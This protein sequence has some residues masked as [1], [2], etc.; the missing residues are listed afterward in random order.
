MI[1]I[2]NDAA[3]QTI[4]SQI[5]YA[6]NSDGFSC[7]FGPNG[8]NSVTR[9]C[10]INYADELQFL[11]DMLGRATAVG[12]SIFR[13]LPEQHPRYGRLFAT[14]AELRQ[15]LGPCTF[16]VDE[17]PVNPIKHDTLIYA[18]TYQAM[19]VDMKEDD[20]VTDAD[21]PE[22]SRFV[23]RTRDFEMDNLIMPPAVMR[24]VDGSPTGAPFPQAGVKLFMS[25]ALSYRWLKVPMAPGKLPGDLPGN[26]EARVKACMGRVNDDWFDHTR[27]APGTLLMVGLKTERYWDFDGA[28]YWNLTYLMSHR[29]NGE[30]GSGAHYGHNWYYHSQSGAFLLVT[31]DGTA[32][33]RKVYDAADF[34]SLFSLA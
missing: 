16:D 34:N 11:S 24:Y 15:G 9:I 22:L 27:F 1:P 30:N 5:T 33:G 18:V 31:H 10:H 20:V 32:G 14:R 2:P 21:C 26:L 4:R 8:E 7:S 28:E 13:D 3:C 23:E 29:D 12:G 17:P 6:E 25:Q 19:P